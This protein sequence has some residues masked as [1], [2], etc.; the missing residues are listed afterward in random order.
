LSAKTVLDVLQYASEPFLPSALPTHFSLDLASKSVLKWVLVYGRLAVFC[1]I[2]IC[3]CSVS[4]TQAQ[5]RN[6]FDLSG[7]TLDL[8]ELR[9]GG[10]PRDGIPSID[11]PKF[12]P[13]GRV[14]YLRDDDIVIGLVRGN[15]ARAYPTRVLIWHEIVNDMI[16]KEAVAVTYCPLCGTAMVFGRTIDGT[17]RT[18]GVSGLLYRSDVLMYDR[19]TESLW[20][21]LAMKAVSGPAVGKALPW[22]PSEHLTFKAWREKYPKGQVLST[23]TGV[24]RNYQ[25]NAYASYFASDKTMFPV[26][27][28]RKELSNKTRV[29]GVVVDGKAKAYVLTDL[30]SGKT[31]K[32]TVADK[33][34]AVRYDTEKQFPQVTNLTGDPIPSVV[35]FWFA[36]QAFYPDT[37]LW[38]P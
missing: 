29:I 10:P 23:D 4:A 16:G 2:M 19:E 25:A 20:S 30:S 18:F 28:T 8:K 15:I 1:A 11:R 35:V 7:L 22:L 37:A 21:Q 26:P 33:Q 38:K 14:D 34:I 32:D 24:R 17:Q 36:W 3:V 5:T 9:S 6:G 13:Q 27:H 31:V 12:I